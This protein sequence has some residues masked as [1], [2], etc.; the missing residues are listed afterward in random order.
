MT[1]DH[2]AKMDPS[3]ADGLLVNPF[4]SPDF[5]QASDTVAVRLEVNAAAA[6][7]LTALR[8]AFDTGSYRPIWVEKTTNVSR[9]YMLSATTDLMGHGGGSAD[10]GILVAYVPLTFMRTGRV[11]AAL[12]TLAER[13]SGPVLPKVLGGYMRAVLSDPDTTLPEYEG[14]AA[15]DL[16]G[17]LADLGEDRDALLDRIWGPYIAERTGHDDMMLLMKEAGARQAML[18]A[19][20]DASAEGTELDSG[21]DFGATEDSPVAGE[22]QD[23]ALPMALESAEGAEPTAEEAYA[24]VVGDYLIAYARAHGSPV[25]ARA[26][27]AYRASGASAMALE[28]KVTKA[29]RKTLKALAEFVDHGVDGIALVFDQFDGWEKLTPDMRASI[30]AAFMEMRWAIDGHGILVVM[31]SADSTPEL[32]EQFGGGTR[33][34]WSVPRIDELAS[35]ETGI[36]EWPI[37]H[38]IDSAA[39]GPT[40][41]ADDPVFPAIREKSGDDPEVFARLAA[42]A[43]YD[44]MARGSDSLDPAFVEA[45]SAVT[46][47]PEEQ[48]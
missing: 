34:D 43:T 44:A 31:S 25:I 28:L 20:P 8:R 27:A 37:Q 17:V 23:D 36:D 24:A 5:E 32:E 26:L 35:W 47:V 13:T 16:G 22:I 29:P 42:A 21:S 41:S 7:L 1:T 38:W 30:A 48:E 10:L 40:I 46:T 18:V 33:I 6:S 3:T 4:T 45:W 39:M 14:L 15:G 9:Y 2:E 11:R 19:D 12:A